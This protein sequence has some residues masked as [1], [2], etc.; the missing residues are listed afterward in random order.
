MKQIDI[1]IIIETVKNLCIDANFH[2]DK[3]VKTSIIDHIRS[4]K[5]TIAKEIL[6]IISQNQELAEKKQMPLCQDTGVAVFFVDIGQDIHVINGSITDAINEG[7]RQGYREGYLRK[8]MVDDP[9]FERI[10]TK[11]NTPAIIHYNIVEGEKIK[12]TFA[13]KGGGAENMSQIKMMKASDGIEG[14]EKFI[15]ES[16]IT[17]G[18][19]P[20]P[21]IILGI[22]IGGSFEQSSL[23]AKKALMIPLNQPNPD[24]K[25]ADV[26]L[27]LLTKINSLDIGPMGLGGDT[28][29]LAV[30][31]L[32]YPCHIASMPVA[33]NFQCH[34][35]RHKTIIIE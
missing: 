28:T 34:C 5:S 30:K 1:K 12:I 8:S 23:L 3:D 31:I 32:T 17:A 10:N 27:R 13:P 22:G 20:C 6:E 4:E 9:V 24:K 15:L 26:E 21:P 35:H 16:V 29:A 19:N 25:W 33:I 2:I 11:D 7:V 18:G 14:I